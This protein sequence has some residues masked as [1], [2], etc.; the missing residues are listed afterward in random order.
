M[1]EVLPKKTTNKGGLRTIPF[2]ISNEIFEKVATFGLHANMILYLTER[3]H[4]TAATGTVVL[5]F[6]NAISNFL[7]IFGAVL[8]DSCLGRFRVIA[9]GSVVSLVV[10]TPHINPTPL[11]D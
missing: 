8:S 5:Y 4:M 9:L 10:S 6:W 7:P 11:M 3:Y 1:E 2:I